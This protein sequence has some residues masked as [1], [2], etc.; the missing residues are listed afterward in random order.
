MRARR[1][2]EGR[3]IYRNALLLLLALLLLFI[4]GNSCLPVRLSSR[5]SGHFLELVRPLL[6]P[7]FGKGNVTDHLVRKLAHFTEFTAL[8]LLMG[9][10]FQ[11]GRRV[12]PRFI[13]SAMLAGLLV[14]LLDETIQMFSDRGDQIKDVWLDFSG[15]VTGV[16]LS[17]LLLTLCHHFSRRGRERGG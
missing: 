3:T 10:L 7:F 4:W 14:A 11:T 9:L 8:G 5:E 15:V 13:L 17:A 1:P 12:R 2:R 16:L 6:E